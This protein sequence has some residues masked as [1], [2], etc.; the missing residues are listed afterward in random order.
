MAGVV[1]VNGIVELKAGAPVCEDDDLCVSEPACPY[2]SRGGL[3]LA[4]ALRVFDIHPI[5]VTAIDIGASTGGFT[6]CLLQN[7]AAKVYALDVGY[8]QLDWKLRNDPRVVNIERVNV[9]TMDAEALGEKAGL[10]TVD[11]SFISL[12]LILP[13]ATRFLDEDG[14]IICLVKPQFEAG[15]AQVGKKGVIK[16]STVHE[17]V[18][19]KVMGYGSAQGLRAVSL[20][21]S[22]IKGAKGNVEFLLLF[23]RSE[24][25][26]PRLTDETIRSTVMATAQ[27]P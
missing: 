27:R 18:I 1:R 3:K 12:K 10:V 26:T 23:V 25:A 8:G 4:E 5:N 2:V 6:D 14:K 19:R 16:D 7:G 13:V 21:A 15:R 20:T 11:V 9:R 24:D 22:P 17:D